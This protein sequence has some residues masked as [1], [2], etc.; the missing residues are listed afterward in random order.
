MNSK[1]KKIAAMLINVAAYA[2]CAFMLFLLMVVAVALVIARP[3]ISD[4][5]VI[6]VVMAMLVIC[7]IEF[8]AIARDKDIKKIG[9]K[10]AENESK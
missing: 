4:M 8:A 1:S 6:S 7:I 5:A 3:P 2:V 9:K 10:E